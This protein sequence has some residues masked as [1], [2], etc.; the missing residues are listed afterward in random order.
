MSVFLF[1]SGGEGRDADQR[2]LPIG[3]ALQ[4]KGLSP[5]LAVP[6]AGPLRKAVD[7]AKLPAVPVDFDGRLG[8]LARFRLSSAMKRRAAVLAHFHDLRSLDVCSGAVAAAKVPVRVL[9]WSGE[10]S[11]GSPLKEARGIDAV[12]AASDGVKSVLVRSGLPENLIEVVP[13]GID[14]SAFDAPRERDFLRRKFSFADD[15]FVVGVVAH[16]DDANGL[17]H[18]FEA[19][20]TIHYHARKVRFVILGEGSLR[21]ESDGGAQAPAHAHEDRDVA[22]FMGYRDETPR[23]LGSLD[24]FVLSTHLEG[25]SGPLL[26][27]MAGGLPVVASQI[28]S[29]PQIVIH[30]ETGLLVPPRDAKALAESV[31]KLILDK[32]LAAR[33]GTAGAEA[34]REK[35]S[36]EAMALRTV[37]LYERLASRK[38]VRLA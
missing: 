28:G 11:A 13:P 33:L 3:R 14:F 23:A 35:F 21:L 19:A 20:K 34:V 30:R 36:I 25:L 38:G 5:F 4:K 15:D 16:L 24:A 27:A 1:G 2:L 32:A 12:I 10:L 9:S 37:A 7:E 17:R 8:L 29:V 6:A 18:L 26:D 22:Y 31:L